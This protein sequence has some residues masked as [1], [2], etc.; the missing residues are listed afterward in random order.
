SLYRP[1]AYRARNQCPDARPRRA[2]PDCDRAIA[3]DVAD[4]ANER[5]N[6]ELES[7]LKER[8]RYRAQASD[9]K[10]YGDRSND[11]HHLIITE[12]FAEYRC[13]GPQ[14]AGQQYAC[15][16]RKSEPCA[17]NSGRELRCINNRGCHPQLAEQ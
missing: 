3:E 11:R 7:P 4:N 9:W 10:N 5:Y 12:V 1:L 2:K 6:V 15:N 13:Q 8:V 16:D 14:Q 17:N